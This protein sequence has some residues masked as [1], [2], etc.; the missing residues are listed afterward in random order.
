VQVTTVPVDAVQALIATTRRQAL[1]KGTE[2]S[3]LAMLDAAEK[4]FAKG[5]RRR[6]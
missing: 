4:A 6:P 2:K 1:P 5:Q 3:L